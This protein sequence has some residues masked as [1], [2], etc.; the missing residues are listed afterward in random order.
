MIKNISVKTDRERHNLL[1][2]TKSGAEE[3]KRNGDSEP[4]DDQS[5]HRAEG[6][7]LRRALVPEHQIDHEEDD[8]D[9]ARVRECRHQRAMLPLR[10]PEELM[11]A[12]ARV[13]SH[14]AH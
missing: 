13:S 9:E 3:D 8:E 4:K 1:A 6:H 12:S 2:E 11:E 5:H 7:R 10:E 14:T